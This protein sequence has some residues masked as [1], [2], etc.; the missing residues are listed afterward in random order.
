MTSL[1][2]AQTSISSNFPTFLLWTK[3]E[4]KSVLQ[5][6]PESEEKVK[7]QGQAY[8]G[9]II[10][11]GALDEL[12]DCKYGRLPYRSLKFDFEHYDKEFYQS[13]GVVNYTVTEDYTRITEF[14]YLSGQLDAKDTTIV[15]EYPMAY[16]GEAG[17]IPYY[18]INNEEND[19]LY[20]KY[21]D[22]IGAIPNFYLLGRLAEY[23]YYNI[24]AIV[25]RALTLAEEI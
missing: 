23:K 8:K 24:D 11:T 12:F 22:Y 25:D 1:L 10:F 16:T 5:I 7:F 18:A 20:K 9:N 6:D 14:K 4:A 19:S 17:Q 13:H 3:K 21:K 15:K 2:L